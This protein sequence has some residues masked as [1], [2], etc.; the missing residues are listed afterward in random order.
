MN[1]LHTLTPAQRER[2]TS[3]PIARLDPRERYARRMWDD[4]GVEVRGGV[5]VVGYAAARD[6]VRYR[7]LD[8]ECDRGRAFFDPPR[9]LGRV[10]CRL[11]R[12]CRVWYSS[13]DYPFRPYDG[14]QRALDA[15]LDEL[16]VES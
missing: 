5:T 7:V 14:A 2:I 12:G 16:G 8:G 1:G 15:V 13:L 6:G 4:M 10:Y 9:E 3:L 11:L